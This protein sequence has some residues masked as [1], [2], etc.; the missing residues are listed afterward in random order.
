MSKLAVTVAAALMVTTQVAVP[1]QA[2]DH[3]VNVDPA[4]AAAVS[5][6]CAPVANVALHVPGH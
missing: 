2:P 5:V 1:V 3:P 4:A 6:T